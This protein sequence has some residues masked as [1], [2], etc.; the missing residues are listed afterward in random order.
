MIERLK[1]FPSLNKKV[2]HL[3]NVYIRFHSLQLL[4]KNFIRTCTCYG[5][6]PVQKGS[7]AEATKACICPFIFQTK[8][9][10]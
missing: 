10:L 3:A 7:A 8:T 6:G 2:H 1:Q 5:I 9:V 4:S